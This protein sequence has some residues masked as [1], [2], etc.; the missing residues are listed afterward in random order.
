MIPVSRTLPSYSACTTRRSVP[1]PAVRFSK[2]QYYNLCSEWAKQAPPGRN[3]KR[4][5]A[6]A[7][8]RD[9]LERTS[10][11]LDL[12][13]LNL[14]SLPMALPD[15]IEVLNAYENQLGFLPPNLPA[16]LL[17]LCVSN[18]NLSC[19][20][21]TL[22]PNLTWLS[23]SCNFLSALPSRLPEGLINLNAYNNMLESLPDTLPSTLTRLDLN[24]NEI[25]VLPDNLPDSL[26]DIR[27]ADN[28]LKGIPER[29][30]AALRYLDVRSNFIRTFSPT[31]IQLPPYAR[32]CVEGNPLSERTLRSLFHIASE[33]SYQGPEILFSM[34]VDHQKTNPLLLSQAV[35]PWLPSEQWAEFE[36]E[37]NAR[38]FSAFLSRLAESKN[39]LETPSF[40]QRVAN[41]LRS[42]AAD[43]TLRQQTFDLAQ[44]AASHCEDR[45][46]LAFNAMQQAALLRTVESGVWDH[47]LPEL[48]TSGRE[49]FRLEQLERIAREKAK[50]LRLVD[51]I[52]IYLA[53]Q[54]ALRRELQLNSVAE[55]MRFYND[56]GVT[57]QDLNRAQVEV[58]SQESSEFASWLTAWAPWKSM[59]HRIY[60]AF[61]D[62]L[63]E[64]QEA[65]FCQLFPQRVTKELKNA[66][67][68][69]IP[70]AEVFLGKK[71]W[72]EMIREQNRVLT[73]KAMLHRY[74][75]KEPSVVNALEA[76]RELAAIAIISPSLA[77]TIIG[78][79]TAEGEHI[80]SRLAA[81]TETGGMAPLAD[82]WVSLLWLLYQHRQLTGEKVVSLL[83]PK[84]NHGVKSL[85]YAI[86]GAAWPCDAATRLCALLAELALSEESLRAPIITALSREQAGGFRRIKLARPADFYKLAK[87]ADTFSPNETAKTLLRQSGLIPRYRELY[88][89]ASPRGEAS[90]ETEPGFASLQQKI[91]GEVTVATMTAWEAM[92]KEKAQIQR[93]KIANRGR[94]EEL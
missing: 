28:Q 49:M 87:R 1:A 51:E 62:E 63:E 56:S 91:N 25:A 57:Q 46:T 52:E 73:R 7:A 6:V 26:Q 59:L 32:V 85:A 9:C 67:V 74:L 80:G 53:Y 8:L 30:P 31:I 88:L 68:A 86:A 10:P 40:Q 45:V 21:E 39:M 43:A 64:Q 27:I 5:E 15:H 24:D 4:D 75:S 81:L 36:K 37:E 13:R 72:D 61:I 89:L 33:N 90:V 84:E 76:V 3:E 42:L 94:L 19:L 12:S 16:S 70:D 83:L 66:G 22:P 18:N 29:L 34:S 60:P 71:V 50:T 11:T 47:K 93:A 41:W 69:N 65:A 58:R 38:A 35:A 14:S 82:A 23:V 79:K 54:T 17:S 2:E 55:M 92:E 20:P 78:A 44:E 48:I 77:A